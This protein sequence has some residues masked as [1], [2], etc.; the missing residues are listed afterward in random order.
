MTEKNIFDD[1]PVKPDD[2]KTKTDNKVTVQDKAPDAKSEKA[3]AADDKTKA[4]GAQTEGSKEPEKPKRKRRTKAEIEADKAAEAEEHKEPDYDFNQLPYEA[5]PLSAV[6]GNVTGVV[7][8]NGAVPVFELALIGW[9]GEAPVS[10]AASEIDDVLD[11][12][13]QLKDRAKKAE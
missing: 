13:Q 9:I 11:V 7:K 6:S 8:V 2:S 12:I 10:I 5:F 1:E 3:Q 4:T